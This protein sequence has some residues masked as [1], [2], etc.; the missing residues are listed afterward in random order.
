MSDQ[1]RAELER[2]AGD[3]PLSAYVKHCIFNK[4]AA[5]KPGILDPTLVAL[6]LA[7]FAQSGL[8]GSMRT[9]S[10]AAKTDRLL[11][12]EDVRAQLR[13]ACDDINEIRLILTRGLGGRGAK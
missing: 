8:A 5:P 9:L 13:L 4:R 10:D 2:H 6:L 1:E 7:R 11:V 3:Q 12:D